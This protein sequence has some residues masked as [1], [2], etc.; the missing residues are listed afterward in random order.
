M[1]LN[2]MQPEKRR[3]KLEEDF[4]IGD[5]EAELQRTVALDRHRMT[6]RQRSELKSQ[7]MPTLIVL[8]LWVLVASFPL[9][10]LLIGRFRPHLHDPVVGMIALALGA[11]YL[12]TTGS[13][14]YIMWAFYADV[15]QGIV[16]HIEGQ[17]H[18]KTILRRNH[19]LWIGQQSFRLPRT[20]RSGVKDREHYR[21]YYTPRSKK[22]VGIEPLE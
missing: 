2:L 6:P 4:I 22:L 12:L 3:L 18:I 20:L 9:A 8:S 21:V 11:F 5:E 19:E 17:A 14:I 10:A 1:R 16:K 7:I 13:V 15:R